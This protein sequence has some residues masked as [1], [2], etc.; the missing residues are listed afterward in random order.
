L[1]GSDA[2]RSVA[3]TG[4]DQRDRTNGEEAMAKLFAVCIVV[5]AILSAIPILAHTWVA[6]ADI[7]THDI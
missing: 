5:I 3:A 6:P 2:A 4:A 1:S 7:S